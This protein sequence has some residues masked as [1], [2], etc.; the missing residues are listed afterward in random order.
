MPNPRN[1]DAER[2][3]FNVSPELRLEAEH[4]ANEQDLTLAQLCRR[5]LRRELEASR[6]AVVITREDGA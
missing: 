4:A 2:I 3:T 5:G 1:P 6:S